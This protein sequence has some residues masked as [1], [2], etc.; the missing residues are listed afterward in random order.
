MRDKD[1]AATGS[2]SLSRLIKE[3]SH[4]ISA[5]FSPKDEPQLHNNLAGSSG[6]IDQQVQQA[7]V[8]PLPPMSLI[9]QNN[10]SAKKQ[11]KL[12]QASAPPAV[13]ELPGVM[14]FPSINSSTQ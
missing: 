11:Q 5:M 4:A 7:S 9:L 8:N 10:S 14:S 3:R 12:K 2:A 13:A 6:S 1:S